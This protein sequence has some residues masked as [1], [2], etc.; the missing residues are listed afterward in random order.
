MR[1][2]SVFV[3]L[4]FLCFILCTKNSTTEPEPGNNAPVIV[5]MTAVPAVLKINM[6]GQIDSTLVT[7]IVTDIDDTSLTYTFN[8]ALGKL[9]NQN[10]KEIT[11]TPPIEPGD[12]VISCTVSDGEA[13]Y[14]DYVSVPVL[15]P[16]PLSKIAFIRNDDN[17]YVINADGS[18]LIRLTDDDDFCKV[19]PSWS[20]DGS[21]IA[22]GA[23][24][25]EIYNYKND[26]YVINSDGTN[27]T[28]LTDD[29][30]SLYPS[31]S[32]DGS[33]IAYSLPGGSIRGG[34]WIMNADGSNK[35][36]ITNSG[37]WP[38][39]SPD[40]SKIAFQSGAQIYT[41]NT[42]GTNQI[43]I[44]NNS[45]SNYCPSW[46]PDGSKIAFEGGDKIYI[47]NTDGTNQICITNN[48]LSYS[49]P[50]WS[51]DG[52]KIAFLSYSRIYIM[53]ADGSNETMLIDKY[54]DHFSWSPIIH[55]SY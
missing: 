54:A 40:G 6:I 55:L 31:W 52:S 27:R 10:G 13:S 28:K 3:L 11:Y 47:M 8:A 20:P 36:R 35:I 32:P 33:N 21:K 17:I 1:K 19:R 29:G 9:S 15:P 43:C 22:F 18:N 46:S 7:V 24:V 16:D 5:S 23:V 49:F 30:N 41:M 37:F 2:I 14:V 42:D 26:I 4:S 38:S 34:I 45:L 25:G 44:T 53:N 39:W 51:P 12:Y 50:F 48:S